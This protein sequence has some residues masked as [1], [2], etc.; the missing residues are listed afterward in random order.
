[1][2]KILH[3]PIDKRRQDVLLRRHITK[4]LWA[5]ENMDNKLAELMELKKILETGYEGQPEKS[6]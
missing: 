5:I 1:M 6:D 4:I 2:A 3:F